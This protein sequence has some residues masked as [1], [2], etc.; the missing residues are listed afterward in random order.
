MAE[1]VWQKV[2]F[3]NSYWEDCFSVTVVIIGFTTGIVHIFLL[4]WAGLHKYSITRLM[5]GNGIFIFLVALC[6]LMMLIVAQSSNDQISGRWNRHTLVEWCYVWKMVEIWAIGL[7]NTCNAIM[8]L[9]YFRLI[10]KAWKQDLRTYWIGRDRTA[11]FFCI[12]LFLICTVTTALCMIFTG[13][14]IINGSYCLAVGSS[15]VDNNLF[16]LCL[17]LCICSPA[18]VAIGFFIAGAVYLGM[19]NHKTRD[20][21]TNSSSYGMGSTLGHLNNVQA[22]LQYSIISWFVTNCFDIFWVIYWPVSTTSNVDSQYYLVSAQYAT[23]QNVTDF[24]VNLHYFIL[25]RLGYTRGF[26]SLCGRHSGDTLKS[27][28]TESTKYLPQPIPRVP[29][30]AYDM[31]EEPLQSVQEKLLISK[32][33][34]MSCNQYCSDSSIIVSLVNS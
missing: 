30:K 1:N 20:S 28:Q 5:L 9:A 24:L 33:H 21:I 15:T 19:L 16:S 18:A 29:S 31:L 8:S 25:P 4:F 10:K 17:A 14:F 13:L 3:V 27:V 6:R 26:S 22:A 32:Y 7:A 34:D 23:L 12:S 2:Q 11:I